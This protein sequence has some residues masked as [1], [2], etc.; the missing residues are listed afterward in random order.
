MPSG[1]RF[2]TGRI[3]SCGNSDRLEWSSIRLWENLRRLPPDRFARLLCNLVCKLRLGNA[4][5]RNFSEGD[6]RDAVPWHS[7]DVRSVRVDF[8]FTFVHAHTQ[9]AH[10]IQLKN[11][12]TEGALDPASRG[13]CTQLARVLGCNKRIVPT[14][15][16]S[17][18]FGF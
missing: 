15:G 16:M 12:S 11:T 8:E 2:P 1:G 9:H 5:F 6:V 10:T 3:P 18:L 4:P 17:C 7:E 14:T 13:V